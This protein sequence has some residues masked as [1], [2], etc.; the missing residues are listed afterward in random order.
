MIRFA[1][2]GSGSKGNATLIESGAKESDTRLLL[3]CGFSTKE[4]ET[5]LAKLCRSADSIDAIVITH[6]HSDHINGVGRL[7]RKYNIPVWL[8]AGTWGK[9]RDSDFPETNFIDCHQ[10]FE[11]QDINLHPFP[12]P[13]DAREPCQFVFSDGVSRLGIATDLGSVTPHVIR[14]LNNLDGLLIEC[15]YDEQMLRNGIYPQ[16]LKER[17]AGDKGHLDNKQS[18][19]LLKCLKLDK[20]KHIIGMHVSEKNNTDEFAIAALCEGLNCEK[21]AVSLASQANGFDWRELA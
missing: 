16:K 7:A 17:V 13:H 18:A 14:Q 8:S 6:E 20:L 3:D 5:R 2:L 11:I 15:N 1:S 9:C 10:G 4:V 12:V 21:S 19:E